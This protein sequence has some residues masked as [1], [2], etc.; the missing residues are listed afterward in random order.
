MNVLIIVFAII[1]GLI[2][3]SR[4]SIFCD[5]IIEGAGDIFDELRYEFFPPKIDPMDDCL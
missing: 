3:L 2:V 4:L 1:L 5:F